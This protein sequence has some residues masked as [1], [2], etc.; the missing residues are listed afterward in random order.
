MLGLFLLSLIAR[1]AT[2]PAA[3]LGVIIGLLV[4]T[5]MTFSDVKFLN[6]TLGIPYKLP[7]TLRSP[8]HTHMTIVVGTLTIFF[9]GLIA[10]NFFGGKSDNSPADSA[11]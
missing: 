9:V 6:D 2:K 10:S 8:F 1:K 3:A 7:A 4:I 5:W 11:A